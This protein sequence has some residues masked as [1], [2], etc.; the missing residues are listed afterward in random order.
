MRATRLLL[1]LHCGAS[2]C[3]L[4]AHP[5]VYF[6][7]ASDGPSSSCPSKLQHRSHRSCVHR[8][9]LEAT[10]ALQSCAVTGRLRRRGGRRSVHVLGLFVVEQKRTLR[11]VRLV[12]RWR[13]G[14]LVDERTEKALVLVQIRLLV[15]LVQ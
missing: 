12:S 13:V 10:V 15:L 11:V 2:L 8:W 7:R 1:L 14:T 3:G 9:I 6:L 5:D 4:K